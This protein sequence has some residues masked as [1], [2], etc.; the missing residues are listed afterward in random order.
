MLPLALCKESPCSV[1]ERSELACRLSSLEV[2]TV[3]GRP[4]VTALFF[5]MV[6]MLVALISMQLGGPA[7][8]IALSFFGAS[9]GPLLGLFLLASLIPWANWIVSNANKYNQLSYNEMPCIH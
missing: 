1:L 9:G 5:G 8:Q 6:A 7:T 3:D 2:L 4:I